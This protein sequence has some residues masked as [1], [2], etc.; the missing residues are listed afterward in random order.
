VVVD[1]VDRLAPAILS[2][3]RRGVRPFPFSAPGR[4]VFHIDDV[5]LDPYLR[6]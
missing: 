3:I 4:A 2:Q 5:E 6:R 1:T